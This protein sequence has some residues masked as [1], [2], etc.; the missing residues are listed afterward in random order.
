M[1]KGWFLLI[2]SFFL[3][4]VGGK[5]KILKVRIFSIG[6]ICVF[7]ILGWVECNIYLF[8]RYF[9]VLL[10]DYIFFVYNSEV[11][12]VGVIKIIF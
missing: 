12:N 8:G 1:I 2:C 5:N 10:F 11:I 4:V 3:D 9:L 7:E 6:K